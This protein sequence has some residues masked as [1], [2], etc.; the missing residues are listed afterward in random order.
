MAEAL[1]KEN[2]SR[3]V[4]IEKFK[5][6]YFIQEI[7]RKEKKKNNSNDNFIVKTINIGEMKKSENAIKNDDN[8]FIRIKLDVNEKCDD[9]VNEIFIDC[10]SK[11]LIKTKNDEIDNLIVIDENTREL[12]T[13]LKLIHEIENNVIKVKLSDA[14]LILPDLESELRKHLQNKIKNMS[15]KGSLID[16]IVSDD[17]LSS[18]QNFY[19][20]I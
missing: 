1:L 19:E 6:N 8:Y 15:D 12:D 10:K 4:E 2:I 7:I 11:T 13:A 14:I 3:A 20:N 9:D 18:T 5:P 16:N 17:F